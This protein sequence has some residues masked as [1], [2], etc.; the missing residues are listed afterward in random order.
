M[1]FLTV[2]GLYNFDNTLLDSLVYPEGVDG[3]LLKNNIILETAE[4]EVIYPDPTFFK[5][6]VGLWSHTRIVTWERVYNAS[7]EEYNPIENYNRYEEETT[8][9]SRIHSGTDTTNGTEQHSGTDS[10][11]TTESGTNVTDG[12]ISRTV[13]G[14]ESGTAN[15]DHS[16]TNQITAFDSNALQTHDKKTLTAEDTTSATRSGTETETNDTTVT[17]SK[18]GSGTITHGENVVT[19]GTMQHGEQI[20]DSGSRESHIHGNI[21]V[22]TS[23][24]MLE[25]ELEVAPK[26]NIYDY[27]IRDFKQRFCLLVY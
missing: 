15:Q 18:T 7:L 24:Q 1:A 25:S 19:S 2:M 10:T 27:I 12:S 6:A 17:D 8:D 23:Q 11:A 14:T 16:E 20:E 5:T 3:T 9:G 22:T 4:M 21:G 13:S 26:L